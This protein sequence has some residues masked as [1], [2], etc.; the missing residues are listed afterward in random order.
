MTDIPVLTTERL[1]LRGPESADLEP[2]AAFRMS[3]RAVGVGGPYTR[4]QAEAQFAAL[5]AHW[6]ALGY[7]RWIVT[8]TE[9]GAPLGVVGILNADGWP[10]PELAWSV[11]APAEGRGIAYEAALAARDYA[12]GTLGMT[13]L[14]SL[15]NLANT[16]SVALAKRLGAWLDG[17]CNI[18]NYGE[19]PLWRHPG[20]AAAQEALT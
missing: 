19:A 9:T 1:T 20:P 6:D 11:F 2:Y 8:E 15:V 7:G 13:T 16:R 3:D 12:Y 10:E 17:T 18:P 4:D 14:V 5:S